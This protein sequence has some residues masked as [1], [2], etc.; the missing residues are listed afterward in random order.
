ML[1]NI[2][3]NIIDELEINRKINNELRSNSDKAQRIERAQKAV[4]KLKLKAP[5]RKNR[6]DNFVISRDVENRR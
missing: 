4:E 1:I 3:D 2:I 6:L 5:E